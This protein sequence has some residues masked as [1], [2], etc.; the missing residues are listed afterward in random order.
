MFAITGFCLCPLGAHGSS[1]QWAPLA[2]GFLLTS[3]S[4]LGPLTVIGHTRVPGPRHHCYFR[5][6]L[7]TDS[8]STRRG[9]APEHP[10]THRH[11]A[12]VCAV[13]GQGIPGHPFILSSPLGMQVSPLLMEGRHLENCPQ[14]CVGCTGKGSRRP[15]EDLVL[16]SDA[17]MMDVSVVLLSSRSRAGPIPEKPVLQPVMHGGSLGKADFLITS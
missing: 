10:R 12:G 4:L 1:C 13:K 6:H 9:T 16:T 3:P 17:D 15:L 5:E 11:G 7:F 14:S 2:F 8:F